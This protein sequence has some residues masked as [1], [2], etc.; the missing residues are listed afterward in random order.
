MTFHAAKLGHHLG[1][2]PD[3]CGELAVVDIGC[4][5]AD[6]VAAGPAPAMLARPVPALLG[7]AGAAHKYVH[8]H[9]LVL[10]GGVGRGGAA[11]LA[12]RAALRVGAG[13]VTL[14]VPAAAL[15]ENAARLDAVMLRRADT[16]DDCTALLG[17]ARL[18]AVVLGPGLGVGAPTRARV[19]AVL[20]AER[21]TVLDAD[22][23]G[24]MWC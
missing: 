11:R 17:D 8:G 14:A 18:S 15:I 23:G 13:L 19:A 21:A 6:A 10:G 20:A 5:A 12:A 7:K 9:A 16:P 2:G 24:A 1:I 4:T 3:V 22:A